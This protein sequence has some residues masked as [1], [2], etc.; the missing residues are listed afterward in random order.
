M[1]SKTIITKLK[2]KTQFKLN[3]RALKI[4][5]KKV[6]IVINSTTSIKDNKLFK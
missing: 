1:P 4:Y 2:P 5:K 3:K 6:N